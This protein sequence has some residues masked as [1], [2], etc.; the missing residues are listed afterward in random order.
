MNQTPANMQTL[1]PG[2]LLRWAGHR[3]GAVRRVFVA[4]GRPDEGKVFQ[5]EVVRRLTRWATDVA[6][7]ATFP[8]VVLLV[9]GPGNG[10]TDA[11]EQFVDAFGEE[12]FC[13]DSLA[14]RCH[15]ANAPGE[16][17]RSPRVIVVPIADLFPSNLQTS[18]RE[19]HIVQDAS[20]PQEGVVQTPE[21]CLLDELSH[22]LARKDVLYLCCLNRGVLADA[23]IEAR[24]EASSTDGL[25][26][27]LQAVAAAVAQG[28]VPRACWPLEGL[29]DIAVWPMDAE[30][31]ISGTGSPGHQMFVDA[32]DSSKWA[33]CDECAA[34]PL[35]P[36][37]ANRDALSSGTRLEVLLSLLRRYEYAS[38]KRWTFRDLYSLVPELLVGNESD[39]RD[40]NKTLEPCDWVRREFQYLE[41]GDG[42]DPKKNKRAHQARLCLAA[43]LYQQALFPVWPS[44]SAA[45]EDA[46]KACKDST[47]GNREA[48]KAVLGYFGQRRNNEE[49]H[50]RRLLHS[51]LAPILDPVQADPELVITGHRAVRDLD[52]AFSRGSKE[53]KDRCRATLDLCELDRYVLESIELAEEGVAQ[54]NV[55]RSRLFEAQRTQSVLRQVAGRYA[56]RSILVRRGFTRDEELFRRYEEATSDEDALRRLKRAFSA[57][58]NQG[59][60]FRASL[61]R[62]VGQ[63]R[64]RPTRDVIFITGRVRAHARSIPSLSAADRAPTI[65]PFLEVEVGREHHPIALTFSLFKALI[66]LEA[67]CHQASLPADV[68][69]LVQGLESKIA[70]QRIR[71][72]EILHDEEVFIELLGGT[73]FVRAEPGGRFEVSSRRPA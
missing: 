59:D 32:L 49:T 60:G 2:G 19:L 23:L 55:P 38:G 57:L 34:A 53:G 43:R 35:C 7:G 51:S 39:F 14:K 30:S 56:K 63:S 6:R 36:F 15:A 8:R 11:I 18:F 68:L 66:R 62:C 52:I 1:F 47:S 28:A 5:T 33:A 9:G 64:R 37:K 13:R 3:D 61:L 46:K 58:L 24:E 65:T 73:L 27:I 26:G 31:L 16:T 12:L 20:V 17:G 41:L 54:G 25:E 4:S 69:A 72:N 45:R 42:R 10:K 70:G 48:T 67:G 21:R 29:P 40:G 71:D 50:I 44:L 22:A